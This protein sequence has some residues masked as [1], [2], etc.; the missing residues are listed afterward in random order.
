MGLRALC[1]SRAHLR[2]QA[3]VA[4]QVLN[5]IRDGGRIAAGDKHS[6]IAE[7]RWYAS[8]PRCDAGQ[9]DGH[10]FEQCSGRAFVVRW[11]EKS[12]EPAQEIGDVSECT[13]QFD[14]TAFGE[15]LDTLAPRSFPRND[16]SAVDA[17]S[18]QN[19]DRLQRNVH[20]LDRMDSGGD[21]DREWLARTAG[22]CGKCKTFQIDAGRD[23]LD[24]ATSQPLVA[25]CEIL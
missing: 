11:E 17:A 18:H 5:G 8:D 23:Q 6:C 7:Q 20:A 24:G 14:V 1:S 12:V 3:G 13:S 15:C 9:S 25:P 2:A 10:G 16:E 22:L 19:A 21:A 4:V